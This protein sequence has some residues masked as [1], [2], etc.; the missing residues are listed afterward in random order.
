MRLAVLLSLATLL[1]GQCVGDVTVGETLPQVAVGMRSQQVKELLGEPDFVAPLRE[2]V[3]W[4]YDTDRPVRVTRPYLASGQITYVYLFF[5]QGV[6]REVEY[7]SA[8][9]REPRLY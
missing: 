1:G 9:L 5:E 6:L 8:V 3:M 7:P 2:R 4:T